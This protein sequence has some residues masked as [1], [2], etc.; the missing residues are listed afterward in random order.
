MYIFV[1]AFDKG[2]I[3]ARQKSQAALSISIRSAFDRK[4]KISWEPLFVVA[5]EISNW[6]YVVLIGH[7]FTKWCEVIK[8]WPSSMLTAITSWKTPIKN[9]WKQTLSFFN[10]TGS[11]SPVFFSQS[12]LRFVASRLCRIPVLV[13]GSFYP[14]YF[15]TE[16]ALY[17]QSDACLIRKTGISNSF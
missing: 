11:R 6:I 3:N 5:Q 13:A 1:P 14:S 15:A 2:G 17:R 4:F 8:I 10:F 16:S 12:A 9:S 7:K